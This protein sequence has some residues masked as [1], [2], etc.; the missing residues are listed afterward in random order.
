MWL[1]TTTHA[2]RA[3]ALPAPWALYAPVVGGPP[4]PVPSFAVPSRPL[5]LSTSAGPCRLHET[6]HRLHCFTT[7]CHV[8]L[9]SVVLRRHS[10]LE[11]EVVSLSLQDPLMP[12]SDLDQCLTPPSS[13]LA[14]PPSL[15][16]YID[17]I[18]TELPP[19]ILP[20]PAPCAEVEELVPMPLP[21]PSVSRSARIAGRPAGLSS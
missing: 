6:R 11:D 2:T 8:S 20:L 3:A 1:T 14:P 5:L 10:R 19:P 17:T 12:F 7:L 16:V 21:T 13:P 4:H 9:P 18:C 15:E